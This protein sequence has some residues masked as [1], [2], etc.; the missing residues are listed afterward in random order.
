MII[1]STASLYPYGLER[2]FQITKEADFNGLELMLRSKKDNAFL[3]S[4]DNKYLIKL[5]QKYKLKIISLHVPFDFEGDQNYLREIIHLAQPLKIKHVV[6]HIPTS[7]QSDYIKWFQEIFLR[8]K[9]IL[10][11]VQFI[12]ENIPYKKYKS[13]PLFM[14]AKNLNALPAVCFDI[15]HA[16]R[17]NQN[18]IAIIDMLNNIKE[19]HISNWDG[20]EDHMS[21]LQDKIKF[22]DILKVKKID[23]YCVELCPKA[24]EDIKDYKEI[25]K[26]LKETYNFIS[27]CKGQLYKK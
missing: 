8:R 10:N 15:A 9:G 4:W 21:I 22:Q 12:A 26:T 5:E 25:T 6:I 2:I 3:D 16:L 1:L 7:N 13:K 11:N 27:Y 18:T 20:K 24:F 14:T 23:V 19:L 17:S